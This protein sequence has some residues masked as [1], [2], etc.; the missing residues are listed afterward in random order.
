MSM[1]QLHIVDWDLSTWLPDN[2]ESAPNTDGQDRNTKSD[3]EH[4]SGLSGGCWH[5]IFRQSSFS[6]LIRGI[7]QHPADVV[8]S[9]LRCYAHGVSKVGRWWLRVGS[10]ASL[11]DRCVC[12]CL[13]TYCSC[14]GFP[15]GTAYTGP[16]QWDWW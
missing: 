6:D 7:L 1:W 10:R 4:A 14:P 13:S 12:V 2:L 8:M 15:S 16:R 9:Q 11:F 3:A 5:C